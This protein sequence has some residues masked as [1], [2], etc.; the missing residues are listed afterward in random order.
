[1]KFTKTFF[2]RV[3]AETIMTVTTENICGIYAEH[4]NVIMKGLSNSYITVQERSRIVNYTFKEIRMIEI[5]KTP[6]EKLPNDSG[7]S[8]KSLW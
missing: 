6:Y 8:A 5:L 3:P 2:R 7:W 1:M 4:K